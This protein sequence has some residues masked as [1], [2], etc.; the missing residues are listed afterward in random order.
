MFFA[1]PPQQELMPGA[2]SAMTHQ[3]SDLGLMHCIDH[4]GRCANAAERVTDVDDVGDGGALAAEIARHRN[5][6]KPL[7]ARSADRLFRKTRI[8]DRRLRRG[9]LRSWR[10]FGRAASESEALAAR[11]LLS[12]AKIPRVALRAACASLSTSRTAAVRTVIGKLKFAASRICMR[13]PWHYRYRKTHKS[14]R[15]FAGISAHLSR[16]GYHSK[17]ADV[18]IIRSAENAMMV[19]ESSNFSHLD[20]G[21]IYRV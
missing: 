3:A 19:P 10:P 9:P 1:E 20:L 7:S 12:A 11:S 14:S 8:A 21:K 6:E 15:Y 13:F 4:G 5:A 16:K 2:A 18:L 17:T